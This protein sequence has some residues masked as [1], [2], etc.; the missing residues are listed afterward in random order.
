MQSN[1]ARES[2]KLFGKILKL[3]TGWAEG[4]ALAAAQV[5]PMLN[6]PNSY[7]AGQQ[8]LE[9]LLDNLEASAEDERPAVRPLLLMSVKQH[10]SSTYLR[11][12]QSLCA[13]REEYLDD[14]VRHFVTTEICDKGKGN[15]V[16]ILSAEPQVGLRAAR[17][18]PASEG[19][20]QAPPQGDAPGHLDRAPLRLTDGA[21]ADRPEAAEAEHGDLAWGGSGEHQHHQA[22]GHHAGCG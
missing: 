22:G 12:V 5:E 16:A 1:A 18:L 3:A 6:N 19:S 2:P 20:P 7:R 21:V 4:R 15:S 10:L 14:A 9:A 17:A 11:T 13:M 8:V